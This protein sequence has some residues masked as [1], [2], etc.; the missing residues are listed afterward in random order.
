VKFWRNLN[1]RWSTWSLPTRISLSLGVIG[2]L[3]V[4]I[5]IAAWRWPDLWKPATQEAGPESRI[6]ITRVQLHPFEAG[7]PAKMNVYFKVEGARA[8]V[9]N[10]STA[11][12]S[13]KP[14]GLRDPDK[15][16]DQLWALFLDATAKNR[17]PVRSAPS[18]PEM[19]ATLPGPELTESQAT[20]LSRADQ[21]AVLMFVGT[22]EWADRY[23]EWH[24]DFCLWT[25]GD[26]R[27]VNLCPTHNGLRK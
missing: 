24:Y 23:R 1:R 22:F 9:G 16:A 12:I 6:T 3:G 18:G 20:S 25:Y 21:T 17:S 8:D 5:T 27:V 19:W 7:K 26:R 11:A 10:Y 4:I 15:A 13:D 2:V 14:E